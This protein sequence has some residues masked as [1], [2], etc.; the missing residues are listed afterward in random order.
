MT[1][2]RDIMRAINGLQTAHG[3]IQLHATLFFSLR[4]E[5]RIA[6]AEPVCSCALSFV[7]FAHETAGA[8]RTRLSL[9]PLFSEE[10]DSGNNPGD[11]RRGNAGLYPLFDDRRAGAAFAPLTSAGF[12]LSVDLRS[13]L[14]VTR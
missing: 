12:E 10:Q 9:C 8:A 5:G 14:T 7:H 4:R 11:P 2:Y 1:P 6:S 13:V 3:S